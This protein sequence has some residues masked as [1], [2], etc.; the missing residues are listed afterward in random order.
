MVGEHQQDVEILEVFDEHRHGGAGRRTG[1]DQPDHH[2]AVVGPVDQAGGQ[3]GGDQRTGHQRTPQLLEDQRRLGQTE[4]DAAG[5]L[6]QAEVE[7]AGFPQTSPTRTVD[8]SI[9][10]LERAHLFEGEVGPTEVPDP[11]GQVHLGFGELEIH[12][13]AALAGPG[14]AGRGGARRR[15]SRRSR[16]GHRFLGQAEDSFADDV[17]LYLR[18]SGGDGQ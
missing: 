15:R 13:P 2:R 10:Q 8:H 16:S 3:M 6:G 14:G 17:A 9:G 5:L 7:H 18:C 4:T 11:V 1:L 12:G